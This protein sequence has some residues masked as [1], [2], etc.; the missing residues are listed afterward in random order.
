MRTFKFYREPSGRWFIDLP[1]WIDAGN[2]KEDLEMVEGADT[3][4]ELIAQGE[5]EVM[6]IISTEYFEGADVLEFDIFGPPQ[7]EGGAY[8]KLSKYL[9][10]PYDIMVWLCDVTKFVFG[11]FPDN[12]YYKKE[13]S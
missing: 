9:G 4:L 8:Y 3:M 12:I 11:E 7:Y 10:I 2:L 1:E 6:V 13:M 5:G